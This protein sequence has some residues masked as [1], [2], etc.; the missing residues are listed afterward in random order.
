VAWTLEQYKS[1]KETDERKKIELE[2]STPKKENLDSVQPV[3]MLELE[4]GYGLIRVVDSSKSGDLLERI[5]SIRKQFSHDLGILVPSIHI[6]D[7]LALAPGEYRFMIKGN[8]VGGGNL[9]P[10]HGDGSRQCR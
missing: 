10:V 6:R 5:S 9:K 7:N 3:D 2:A 1:E 8:K 4:V